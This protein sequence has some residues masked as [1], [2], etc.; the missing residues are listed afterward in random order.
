MA[1]TETSICNSALSKIG[2]DRINSLTEDSKE[3][4]LCNEQ[5]AKLRNEVLRSHP[6]NFAIKRKS[7][8]LSAETPTFEYD[9]FFPIPSDCLRVLK[10]NDTG[11]KFKI[12]GNKIATDNDEISIMYIAKI[13]NTALFSVD[14][15]EVLAWRIAADL[16]YSI[17]QSRTV[18]ADTMAIYR[19]FLRNARSMDAQEGSPE[20]FI[21]DTWIE[22][23]DRGT[24]FGAG[25]F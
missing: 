18:W 20:D 7:L 17:V 10:V 24:F 2:A 3:A 4:R 1:I 21:A 5:Y 22:S 25:T 14:F 23:R 12:E 11:V 13:T 19:E 9:N 15:A 8:S 16:A 6:W